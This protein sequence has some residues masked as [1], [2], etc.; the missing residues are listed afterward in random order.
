MLRD[1]RCL[2]MH[3]EWCSDAMNTYAARSTYD[4][5][6]SSQCTQQGSLVTLSMQ[7][8]WPERKADLTNMHKDHSPLPYVRR[9]LKRDNG[10]KLP[11]WLVSAVQQES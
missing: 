3:D 2:A 9:D 11:Y 10:Y 7:K 1:F 6:L 8:M 4:L 5:D